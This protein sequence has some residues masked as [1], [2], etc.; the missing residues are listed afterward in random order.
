MPAC[1]KVGEKRLQTISNIVMPPS[2]VKKN[3]KTKPRLASI[4]TNRLQNM[5]RTVVQLVFRVRTLCLMFPGVS[6]G[7]YGFLGVRRGS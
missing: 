2:G 5:V 7:S 3:L 6:R 1:M 4:C